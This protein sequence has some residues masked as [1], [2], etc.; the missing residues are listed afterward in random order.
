M[1]FDEYS[2]GDLVMGR[3]AYPMSM[4]RTPNDWDLNSD[5]MWDNDTSGVVLAV[6]SSLGITYLKILTSSSSMGWMMETFV[7]RVK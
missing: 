3:V 1:Y 5:V 7:K 4:H 6:V 2:I